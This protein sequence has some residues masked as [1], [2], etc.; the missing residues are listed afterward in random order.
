MDEVIEA[1]RK[2]IE[3]GMESP[4]DGLEDT[5][6]AWVLVD[7]NARRGLGI[8]LFATEEGMRRGDQALDGMSPP[9]P[10]ADAGGRRTSVEL[11]EVVVR[12]ERS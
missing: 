7:R 9:G 10:A 6:G 4:P 3:A 1:N 8:T 5:L 2:M 12:A 11:Y